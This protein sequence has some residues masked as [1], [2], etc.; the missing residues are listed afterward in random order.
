M[1]MRYVNLIIKSTNYGVIRKSQLFEG[2]CCTA[3]RHMER[4]QQRI[5]I[6][7]DSFEIKKKK[8]KVII[9]IMDY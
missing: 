6:C 3:E 7:C 4:S 2:E 8:K 5:P 1:S 9:R